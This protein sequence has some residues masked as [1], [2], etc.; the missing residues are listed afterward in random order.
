MYLRPV[1]NVRHISFRYIYMFNATTTTTKYVDVAP[2]GF[3]CDLDIDRRSAV[4]CTIF[5]V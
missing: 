2:H 4:E 1:R 3:V 5:G